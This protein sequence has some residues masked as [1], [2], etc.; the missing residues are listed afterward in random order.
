MGFC[1]SLGNYGRR[2]TASR[3]LAHWKRDPTTTRRAYGDSTEKRCTSVWVGHD[4]TNPG[5]K[6]MLP[7]RGWQEIGVFFPLSKRRAVNA[8]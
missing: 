4:P 2:V 6:M 7:A 3:I 8:G 1:N 5:V